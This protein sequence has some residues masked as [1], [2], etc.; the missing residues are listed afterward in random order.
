MFTSQPQ[1]HLDAPRRMVRGPLALL[2]G[3]H[4]LCL[5]AHAARM[6][7][8]RALSPEQAQGLQGLHAVLTLPQT[9]EGMFFR[10]PNEANLGYALSMS[11]Q[12]SL[13]GGTFAGGAVTAGMVILLDA[14]VTQG[15]TRRMQREARSRLLALG[16][17]A[18]FAELQ[19][20]WLDG[21]A[22]TVAE[23]SWVVATSTAQTTPEG[24]ARNMHPCSGRDDCLWV[25][26]RWGFSWDG[27]RL[28]TQTRVS[29][30]S[31][32]LRRAGAKPGRQP[33]FGNLLVYL[34]DP[35]QLAESPT[36]ADRV[37][38]RQAARQAYAFHGLPALIAQSR[39]PRPSEASRARREAV[40]LME[41]HRKRMKEAEAARWSDD[42]RAFRAIQLW[43]AS[44]AERLHS[45]L[46]QARE[47]TLRMLQI[48]LSAAGQSG[49][50]GDSFKL[51]EW[52][53]PKRT[54]HVDGGRSIAYVNDGTL[55]SAPAGE[56][57]SPVWTQ[58]YSEA[59]RFPSDLS[60]DEVP[61]GH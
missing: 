49:K 23:S 17:G 59:V 18:D 34:S 46:R 14:A 51:R 3:F 33:D 13:S 43:G 7:K 47:E 27:R 45:A 4:L 10:L 21:I 8:D 57:L 58:H 26:T 48:E 35:V 52:N 25:D 12:P 31:P 42:A 56:R 55:V 11:N 5:P 41:M 28:E 2:L 22:A 40:P 6:D 61:D 32:S 44:G 37:A 16:A 60:P 19:R 30:W 54:M 20:E 29:I 9:A 36:E 53:L 38:L 50:S 15:E 1:D 24:A 39:S